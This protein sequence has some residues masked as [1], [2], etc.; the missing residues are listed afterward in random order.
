MNPGDTE[1]TP[2]DTA[3]LSAFVNE[4][5]QMAAGL[6]QQAIASQTGTAMGGHPN[7]AYFNGRA[8]ALMKAAADLIRKS[9]PGVAPFVP[10]SGGPGLPT[11]QH[12]GPA[13][14]PD[15]SPGPAPTPRPVQP[16]AEQPAKKK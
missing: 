11:V 16:Q 1:I 15:G 12:T 10:E 9:L 2:A 8:A 3:D 5:E 7:P 13:A 4:C 6:Q 14:T